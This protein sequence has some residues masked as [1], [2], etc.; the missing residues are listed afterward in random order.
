M[1]MIPGWLCPAQT[2]CGAARQLRARN[3]ERESCREGGSPRQEGGF[4]MDL[5]PEDI[6]R[7]GDLAE[8]VD[9]H[10]VA[11]YCGFM[12]LFSLELPVSG[13]ISIGEAQILP[14]VFSE[15]TKR[16]MSSEKSVL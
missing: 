13:S 6:T 2:E 12:V 8:R 5:L 11:F 15:V 7:R 1:L 14:L 16:D 3:C 10:I 9:I 4:L